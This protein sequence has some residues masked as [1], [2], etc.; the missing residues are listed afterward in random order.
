MLHFQ[1]NYLVMGYIK[2]RIWYLQSHIPNTHMRRVRLS[3]VPIQQPEHYRVPKPTASNQHTPTPTAPSSIRTAGPNIEKRLGMGHRLGC[4]VWIL[5]FDCRHSKMCIFHTLHTIKTSNQS[6]NQTSNKSTNPK[7]TTSRHQS[8]TNASNRWSKIKIPTTTTKQATHP[9]GFK[10]HGIHQNQ[11]RKINPTTANVPLP[12]TTA[13]WKNGHQDVH[14]R[15]FIQKEHTI[16]KRHKHGESIRPC[17]TTTATTTTAAAHRECSPH[18]TIISRIS[19]SRKR[20][21]GTQGCSLEV[22]MSRFILL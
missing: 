5:Y 8:A 4:Y 18:N 9:S 10:I 2:N 20:C 12:T 21:Q 16:F 19:T 7:T 1:R 3:M 13:S 11:Q 15:F 6:T 22:Q 17:T 14:N